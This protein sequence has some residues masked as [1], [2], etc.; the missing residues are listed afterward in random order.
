MI[1]QKLKQGENE[2]RIESA[3]SIE[4]AKK[5]GFKDSE[6]TRFFVNDKPVDSYM[7]LIKYMVAETHA[8]REK[9]IPD[10]ENLI[11]LRDKMIT[12]QNAEMKRQVSELRDKYKST[13]PEETLINLDAMIDKIDEYGVRIKQ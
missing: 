12:D 2:I 5:N 7:T 4:D 13:L 9:F 6:F 11:K 8:N 1:T 3:D 10:T